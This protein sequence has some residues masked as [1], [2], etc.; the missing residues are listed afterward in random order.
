MVRRVFIALLIVG[1]VAGGAVGWVL[2]TGAAPEDLQ[3][4]Q[5]RIEGT[6]DDGWQQLAYRGLA[7]ETPAGWVRLGM[8]GCDAQYERWGPETSDPCADGT[9]LWFF[10]S[11]TYDPRDGPGV[12]VREPSEGLPEGGAAG[13][14]IR[15]SV[16]VYAAD[17]DPEVV[18]RILRSVAS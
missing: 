6:T 13:Y 9:G 11:A 17:V 5:A 18:R 7:L 1:L 16:V 15:G 10:D 12:Q 4:D 3:A 14:V 8:A 2:F